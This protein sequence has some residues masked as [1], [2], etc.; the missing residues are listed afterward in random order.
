MSTGAAFRLLLRCHVTIARNVFSAID[1]AVHFVPWLF[2]FFGVLFTWLACMVVVMDAR[3][4]RDQYNQSNVL[5]QQ[6]VD[7]LEIA[8]EL[9]R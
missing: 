8:L 6:K 2:I 3:A 1:G 9:R 7:S 4:E 5:Y